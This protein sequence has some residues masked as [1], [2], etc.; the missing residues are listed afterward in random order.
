[1]TTLFINIKELIQIR[2][3]SIKKVSGKQMNILPTIKNAFLII[4]DAIIIDYGSMDN[5]S[6]TTVDNTIDCTGK[7]ILPT[8]CD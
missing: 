6:K 5:L 8:W 4:K 3:T 2:D 1:M 7:M